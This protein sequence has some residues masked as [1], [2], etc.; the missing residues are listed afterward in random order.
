[1]SFNTIILLMYFTIESMVTY[2]MFGLYKFV[3]WR[4]KWL[5]IWYVDSC[6]T[7]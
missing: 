7:Y 5:C 1:M 3:L 4:S 6:A 2:T